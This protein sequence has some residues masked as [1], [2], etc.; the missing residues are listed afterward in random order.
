MPP[1]I[2]RGGASATPQPPRRRGIRNA[3]GASPAP[4]AARARCRV[5]RCTIRRCCASCRRSTGKLPVGCQDRSA[6]QH[7]ERCRRIISNIGQRPSGIRTEGISLYKSTNPRRTRVL[8]GTLSCSQWSIYNL[9]PASAL[10]FVKGLI[11]AFQKQARCICF[12]AQPRYAETGRD[13]QFIWI[14]WNS[15]FGKGCSQPF[16]DRCRIRLLQSRHN[17]E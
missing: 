15:E 17:H 14:G 7:D 6:H 1:S 11:R 8:S 2:G 12:A 3:G 9:V 10:R 4:V 13:M 5:A 16:N